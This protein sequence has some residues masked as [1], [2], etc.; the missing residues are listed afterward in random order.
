MMR[1]RSVAALRWPRGG[2]IEAGDALI[3]K[4][5]ALIKFSLGMAVQWLGKGLAVN[6]TTTVRI[7]RAMNPVRAGSK[8]VQH[9]PVPLL[10]SLLAVTKVDHT[11]SDINSPQ[12]LLQWRQPASATY[13]THGRSAADRFRRSGP[14]CAAP[15]GNQS[16]AMRIL[17]LDGGAAKAGL[18]E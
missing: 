10:I 11:A 9:E 17:P 13:L 7:T 14:G 16:N 18:P 2:R 5:V 12:T 1:W 4:G 6:L 8:P 15:T 3:E